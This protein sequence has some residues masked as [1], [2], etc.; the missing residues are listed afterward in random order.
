MNRVER[1]RRLYELLDS[2]EAAQRI[3]AAGLTRKDFAR[4][5]P[6]DPSAVT[7]WL[8]GKRRP[9]GLYLDA[10]WRA[11]SRLCR[12]VVDGGAP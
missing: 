5:V 9:S 6:A 8:N 2:G 1:K 10:A 4:L 11:L 7:L 12:G 3:A